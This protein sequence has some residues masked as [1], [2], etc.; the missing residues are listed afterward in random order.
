MTLQEGEGGCP[1]GGGFCRGRASD[2]LLLPMPWVLGCFGHGPPAP[3]TSA[4][5][6]RAL[7][8]RGEAS[9]FSPVVGPLSSPPSLSP[10]GVARPTATS[11][12]GGS[13]WALRGEELDPGGARAGSASSS[14]S[15]QLRV[16]RHCHPCRQCGCAGGSVDMSQC[17]GPCAGHLACPV[18]PGPILQVLIPP[19]SAGGSYFLDAGSAPGCWP[20]PMGAGPILQL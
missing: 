19:H 14:G 9:T 8:P 13:C 2:P 18:G 5:P 15:H 7:N 10:Q 17:W 4:P 6:D 20:Q 16:L 1:Q 11:A 3:S 12:S